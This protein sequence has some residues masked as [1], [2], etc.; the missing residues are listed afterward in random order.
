MDQNSK[1]ILP[2]AIAACFGAVA[3]HAGAA[4]TLGT[5][6]ATMWALENPSNA[7]L[8]NPANILDLSLS[9]IPGLKAAGSTPMYMKVNLLNGVTFGAVPQLICSASG[10]A[11]TSNI[12]M[13]GTIDIGGTVGANNV[14]FRF[15]G[16]TVLNDSAYFTSTGCTLSA[17]AYTISG[18][19]NKTASAQI[20][21]TNGATVAVT[22][23]AGAWISFQKGLSTVVSAPATSVAVDATS[24]SDNWAVGSNLTV[25]T[26]YLGHITY[27]T[28]GVSALDSAGAANIEATNYLDSA[29]LTI[30][31]PSVVA[32]IAQGVTGM[33]LSTVSGCS[34]LGITANFTTSG[35]S[36]SVT[37][38]KLTPAKLS[39]AG[40]A[41][42]CGVVPGN[43]V[44][45]TGQLTA[46]LGSVATKATTMTLDVSATSNNIANV[47]ANGSTR[48]AYMVNAST[49]TSKTSVVRLINKGGVGGVITATAYSEAGAL[50]GTANT[51]LGTLAANQMLT[52]TSAEL[53]TLLGFTPSGPTAKY[54]I[55]FS[56]AVPSF[57]VLNFSKDV[58]GAIT[59]RNTSTTNT[60]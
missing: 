51:S 43:V 36:T 37:F 45:T 20:E 6:N 14:T 28:N 26:A 58:S 3:G 55:V 12:S 59:L 60:Q 29:T 48:N 1:K 46:T 53:E 27:G 10:V 8:Q 11:G 32:M 30:S 42:I 23:V 39:A 19:T 40:G 33:Y 9:A 22:G 21:Y 52:K 34:D 31:G 35:S 44:I 17:A 7:S 15:T 56:G 13:T 16:S 57:E 49:S 18:T 47:T 5:S 2:L 38:T 54:S 41:F 50:L 25:G 4:V 24:G